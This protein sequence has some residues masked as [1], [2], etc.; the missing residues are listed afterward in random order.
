MANMK[1]PNEYKQPKP[2]GLGSISLEEY[3]KRQP[4][5]TELDKEQQ[6]LGDISFEEYRER[7]FEET[8]LG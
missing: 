8:E 1:M 6:G 3:K 2:Q 5:D 4:K 7:S